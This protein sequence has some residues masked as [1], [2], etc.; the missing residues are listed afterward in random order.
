MGRGKVCVGAE[1]EATA[2]AG[3][4]EL[5]SAM[6]VTRITVSVGGA[7]EVA[8]FFASVALLMFSEPSFAE[9]AE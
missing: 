2:G 6:D 5:I 3:R 9:T 7:R 8:L 4:F 1:G